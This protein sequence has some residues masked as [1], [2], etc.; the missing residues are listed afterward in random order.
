MAMQRPEDDHA[1]RVEHFVA[2]EGSKLLLQ[3]LDALQQRYRASRLAL[4]S[5]AAYVALAAL[6]ST[7]AKRELESELLAAR[8]AKQ[9]LNVAVPASQQEAEASIGRYYAARLEEK[10]VCASLPVVAVDLE[11]QAEQR[12]LFDERRKAATRE[13]E[14][15]RRS[16]EKARLALK[17]DVIWTGGLESPRAVLV[18]QEEAARARYV[19]ALGGQSQLSAS[20]E[21]DRVAEAL[22]NKKNL[23]ESC[24]A[25]ALETMRAELDYTTASRDAERNRLR[26][27]EVDQKLEELSRRGRVDIALPILQISVPTATFFKVAPALLL[28]FYSLTLLSSSEVRLREQ[29]LTRKVTES[30]IDTDEFAV[31]APALERRVPALLSRATTHLSVALGLAA[32]GFCDGRPVF[33]FVSAALVLFVCASSSFVSIVRSPGRARPTTG[34]ET[35]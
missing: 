27:V 15:G 14:E 10:R 18:Q 13:L 33:L 32:L 23:T 6:G 2:R 17:G 29:Y 19:K 31:V 34:K 4:A 26:R 8:A 9:S 35:P 16:L 28:L 12:R 5:L 21:L 3:G 20:V 22:K 24:A 1:M 25:A 11:Q 7:Q 30:G